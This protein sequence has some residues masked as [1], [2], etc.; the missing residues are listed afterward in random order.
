M[1]LNEN[2]QIISDETTTADTMNKYF[3]SITK[4]LK[5][6]QW[7]TE[8]NEL[9]LSEILNKY[10]DHQSNVKI[11]SQM[12][13][14]KNLF[15]FKPVTSEEVL[16]TIYALKDNK[17]SLSYTIPVKILKTDS[18]S[19]LPYLTGVINHSKTISPFPDELKLAEV[20]SAFKRDDLHK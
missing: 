10:K 19:F 14:K 5:L 6:K 3:V 18:G 9:S 15:S 11:R 20:I 7:E 8:I 12:N 4:K 13:G 1:M 16:N 2:D 17:R